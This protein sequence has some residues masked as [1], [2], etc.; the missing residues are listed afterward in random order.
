MTRTFIIISSICLL[1]GCGSS[2][3][4]NTGLNLQLEN[5][6]A[7]TAHQLTGVAVSRKGRLFTNYPRW[8]DNYRYAVAEVDRGG[9]IVPYPDAEMNNWHQPEDG[10]QKWVCVQAVHVDDSD[11]LWVVDAASPYQKGVYKNSQKLVQIDLA[12]DRV[13]RTYPLSGATDNNSYINDVR[14]DRRRGVAYLTNSSEG[15]IV[16]VD[17]TTGKARQVLQGTPPVMADPS[18]V[19]AIDGHDVEKNGL[20][21]HGNSDGIAL[22]PDGSYLYFRALTDSRLYRVKTTDLLDTS[23]S[24]GQLAAKV[25]Q[26]GHFVASDGMAIDRHGNIYLGDLERHAIVRIDT[27]LT[28]T[29]LARDPRLIWPDSYQLS[30]SG[31]LYVSCSQIDRQ[32][33]FNN[34]VSKRSGPYSIYRIRLPE[35][36]SA[37]GPKRPR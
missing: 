7:D 30:D 22:S 8:S 29:T 4:P 6:F 14:V 18:Y 27:G 35:A 16:I 31:Y 15:G 21:F 12:T 2:D 11:W 3:P 19:L 1:A 20:P 26:L 34:G 28:T 33:D 36:P 23:L 13:M 17:L 5:V 10:M 37:R 9:K 32:P 25:V 24:A